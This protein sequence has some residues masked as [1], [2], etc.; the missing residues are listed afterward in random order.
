MQMATV[1]GCSVRDMTMQRLSISPYLRYRSKFERTVGARAGMGVF[2][3]RQLPT[4]RE[5]VGDSRQRLS[6]D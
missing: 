3:C 4:N 1:V 2:L 5:I 6:D